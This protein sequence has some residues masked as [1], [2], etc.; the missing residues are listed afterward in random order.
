MI[1][2]LSEEYS[3]RCIIKNYPKPQYLKSHKKNKS[4]LKINKN[5]TLNDLH[6][7]LKDFN[8]DIDF[9]SLNN[10]K[11]PRNL[12]LK[13]IQSYLPEA[14]DTSE[15]IKSLQII[16]SMRE[17]HN[18]SDIDWIIRIYR[19]TVNI[20]S[21]KEEKSKILDSII[22]LKK[23]NER[24]TERDFNEIKNLIKNKYD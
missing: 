17:T 11:V 20:A 4:K 8:L 18:Y 3:L 1:V 10:F 6:E 13:D 24:F 7:F 9:L 5:I 22:N 16:E 14:K 23:S 2:Y 15:V 19:Y 21:S 12:L